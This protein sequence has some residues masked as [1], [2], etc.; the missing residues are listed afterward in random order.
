MHNGP[1][2]TASELIYAVGDVHGRYDLLQALVDQIIGDWRSRAPDRR[3][4]V[5][6]C[7]DYVDRGPQSAEV[8]EAL[9]QLQAR[10]DIQVRC[11]KGNHE[12]GFQRFIEEPTARGPRST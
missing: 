6:F 2:Q 9:I 3:P 5:I 8:I 12:Q 7:G 4:L 11:L 1:R 10:P